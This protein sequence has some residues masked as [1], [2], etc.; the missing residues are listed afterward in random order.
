MAF[1]LAAAGAQGQDR[2]I[3]AGELEDAGVARLTDIASLLDNWASSS[4]EGYSRD[5]SVGG[6][7]P[8][9]NPAWTLFVDGVPVDLRALGMQDMNS[10]PVSLTEIDRVEVYEQPAVVAG[11]FV[12][13]GALDIRTRTSDERLAVRAAVIGGNESGDPGPFRYTT[14]KSPN[15]DRI[16]PTFQGSLSA[17]GS[18]W[19][20]RAQ[21]KADEHHATDERIRERVLTLYRGEKA[22]RL[23]LGAVRAEAGRH[24]PRGRHA[25]F[26]SASR[27][28]GLWFFDPLGL[29]LPAVHEFLQ[30][31]VTGDRALGPALGLRWAA[32]ITRSEFRARSNPA[33]HEGWTDDRRFWGHVVVSA[34]QAEAGISADVVHTSFTG[35]SEQ[36]SL[37]HLRAYGS[38]QHRM[39]SDMQASGALVAS[40]VDKEISYAA[41]AGIE[42]VL[43]PKLTITAMGTASRR[44]PAQE[45]DLWYRV[46]EGFVPPHSASIAPVSE[47]TA[48]YMLTADLTARLRLSETA[49]FVLTGD[50][51]DFRGGTLVLMSPQYDEAT[52]GFITPT[53][54]HAGVPGRTVRLGATLEGT[55]CAR[56]HMRLHYGLLRPYSPREVFHEGW[57]NQP[58]RRA[59]VTVRYAA[60][61]RLTL[62]AR[63]RYVGQSHWAAYDKAADAS[64]GLYASRIPSAHLLDVTVTKSLWEHRMVATMSL[65]NVLNH[66]HRAHPA[67]AITYMALHIGLRI[68]LSRPARGRAETD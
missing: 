37:T 40:Q 54:L 31:G 5:F 12:P 58:A 35:E 25:V 18:R 66:A 57:R 3:T 33:G 15:I 38:F 62:F 41:V 51:R 45:Q 61:G 2:V 46:H 24:S 11:R 20:V 17:A 42:A 23:I 67:G 47:S 64:G 53:S 44:V 8:L 52:T 56:L 26:G 36:R 10:L 1:L 14:L 28:S 65:R 6:L 50:W 48:A 21:G 63:I 4:V 13:A 34:R 59:S 19:F 29:E 32:T 55:L 43:R 68:H 27:L 7:A 16:G 22:P 49:R 39:G 30:A 60:A 9:G